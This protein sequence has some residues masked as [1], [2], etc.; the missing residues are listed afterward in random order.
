MIEMESYGIS[1]KLKKTQK[2]YKCNLGMKQTPAKTPFGINNLTSAFL[3]LIF[4][5]GLATI[6]FIFE[7]ILR[8]KKIL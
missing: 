5:Y 6:S 8:A 3:F 1:V 4:G 7:V 2:Y